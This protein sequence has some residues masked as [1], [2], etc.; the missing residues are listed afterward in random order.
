VPASKSFLDL[1]ELVNSPGEGGKGMRGTRGSFTE[2]RWGPCRY[3]PM[4]NA[5]QMHASTMI[6]AQIHHVQWDGEEEL[7]LSAV[8]L[9]LGDGLGLGDGVG[10]GDGDGDGEALPL[11]G[12][13]FNA[14]DG[15]GEVLP[16]MGDGSSAGDGLGDGEA[17]GC[18]THTQ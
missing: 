3:A 1:K 11:I 7:L 8:A 17:T 18:S 16:P 15:D 14:G 5:T 12:D 6:V 13:G 2:P 10:L 9:P 4:A